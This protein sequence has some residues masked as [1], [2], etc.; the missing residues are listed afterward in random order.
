MISIFNSI[1]SFKGF[2]GRKRF[3]AATVIIITIQL[4]CMLAITE[5][6][7]AYKALNIIIFIS[8]ISMISFLIR[9][10]HD[11]GLSGWLV[12]PVLL[13]EI[14]LILFHIIYLY[15]LIIIIYSILC[16]KKRNI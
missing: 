13:I 12:I 9:R 8:S 6:N 4:L 3:I 2:I 15:F 7:Q 11:L 1:F 14:I 16:I 5:N 10:L